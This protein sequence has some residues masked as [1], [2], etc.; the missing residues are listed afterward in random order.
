[1]TLKSKKNQ[2][3]ENDIISTQKLEDKHIDVAEEELAVGN[4]EIRISWLG[5]G[6]VRIYQMVFIY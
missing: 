3:I 6:A 5:L 4:S 1:M 2:D